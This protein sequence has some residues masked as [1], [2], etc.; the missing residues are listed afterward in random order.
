MMSVSRLVMLVFSILFCGLHPYATRNGAETLR[1]EILGKN[2][3]YTLD[4]S[5]D[6]YIPKGG[7]NYIWQYL[8]DQIKDMLFKT[9]HDGIKFE[10]IEWYEA[11]TDYKEALASRAYDDPEAYKAFPKMDYVATDPHPISMPRFTPPSATGTL[12]NSPF[13]PLENS[14]SGQPSF[15]NRVN[16]NTIGDFSKPENKPQTNNGQSGDK[17]EGGLLGLFKNRR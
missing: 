2:F 14:A 5:L 6:E 13:K 15:T 3:P 4:G 11:V 8:P 17:N 16:R 12:G 7:Y 1:E 9:F 10:A